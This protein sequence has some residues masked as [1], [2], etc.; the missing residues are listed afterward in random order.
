M[1]VWIGIPSIDEEGVGAAEAERLA[2][3]DPDD[4]AP[5]ALL[6]LDPGHLPPEHVLDPLELAALDV[7]ALDHVGVGGLP[8]GV[9]GPASGDAEGDQEKGNAHNVRGGCG[10]KVGHCRRGCKVEACAVPH[11]PATDPERLGSAS[12]APR[13]DPA[14]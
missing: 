10:L 7:L 5:V 13:D 8:G 1:T 3:P 12:G 11:A 2:P 9:P 4:Q 14:S 6:D